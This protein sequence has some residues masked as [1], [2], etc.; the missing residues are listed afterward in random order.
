MSLRYVRMV[1]LKCDVCGADKNFGRIN[2]MTAR[3]L[4]Q[5]E[6]WQYA[7]YLAP[8]AQVENGARRFAFDVCPACQLPSQLAPLPIMMGEINAPAV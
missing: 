3:V 2:D 1:T 6:G 7:I 8:E 5:R 4:A